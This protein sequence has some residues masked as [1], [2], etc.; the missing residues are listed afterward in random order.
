[1]IT[2]GLL[3]VLFLVLVAEFVNGWTD[4]PNAIVTVVS[5]RVMSMRS[6]V[7]MAVILNTLGTMAGTAVAVTVGKGIV[8]QSAITLPAIAAAMI[9]II[10]W[11]TL[12]GKVGM[13]VSKSHALLA[14]IAGAGVAGGGFDALLWDGWTKVII[15]MLLAIA[16]GFV[17]A[18]LLGR[19]I[20]VFAAQATPTRAKR[21]FDHLQRISAGSMAFNHGLNDGQKFVGIFALVFVLGHVTEKF[22]IT[23]P[24]ILICAVT[25][26]LGTALGGRKIMKT[27]GQKMTALTS[28]QGFAAETAASIT[29]FGASMYGVPLST[30][31]TINSA[32]VGA[33]SSKRMRDVRWGVLRSI[34]AAW[35]LTFPICGALAFFAATIANRLA[36]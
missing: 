9:T 8:T 31:H 11:G 2:T 7:I 36:M 30:T 20:I 19:A 4:A 17:A 35:V 29:I 23:M 14:G 34:V 6:A 32:I 21:I 22:T 16:L 25:M 5:T 12:A 27:V 33:A 1:M 18:H 26:G 3:I 24:I 13:P 28:W 10:A 15:G